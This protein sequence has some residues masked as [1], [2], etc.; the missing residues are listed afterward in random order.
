MANTNHLNPPALPNPL[1]TADLQVH[2]KMHHWAHRI[3]RLLYTKTQVNPGLSRFVIDAEIEPYRVYY[4][5]QGALRGAGDEAML[6]WF[7]DQPE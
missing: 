3:T 5:Q 4:R 1:S 2:T 7:Y 6:A